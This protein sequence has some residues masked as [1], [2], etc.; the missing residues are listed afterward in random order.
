[1]QTHPQYTYVAT[2]FSN[3]YAD[4]VVPA[5]KS[6]KVTREVVSILPDIL[7]VRDR[8]T[9]TGNHEVLFHVWSGSGVLN[10]GAREMTVTHGGGRGWLKTVFPSNATARLT[11]Q[12]ATNLLTV[13]ASGAGAPVDFLHIVYLTPASDSFV[14]SELIPLTTA[15]QIGASIR[16][17]QGRLWS[18]AFQRSGVGLVSVTVDG[19]GSS[20]PSAPTGIRITPGL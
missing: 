15:S 10:E 18:V 4:A 16:D 13:A 14:P 17:K 5:P 7:L 9:G 8:V 19:G 12:G 20:A 1:M 3:A 6:G 2:D 11:T